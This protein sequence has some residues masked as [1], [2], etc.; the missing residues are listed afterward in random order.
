MQIKEDDFKKIVQYARTILLSE[1]MPVQY[2]GGTSTEM[3]SKTVVQ[4]MPEIITLKGFLEATGEKKERAKPEPAAD[5]KGFAIWWK[6]YPS[7]ANFNYKGM[8]FESPRA[9]RSNYQVCQNLYLRALHENPSVTPEMLLK[10]LQKQV[11]L[12]KKE[13][14]ETGNNKLAYFP[15][16]EVYLR[17]GRYEAFITSQEEEVVEQAQEHNDEN[18]G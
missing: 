5:D 3:V 18:C 9:L 8:K 16:S 14:F 10:A 12:A 2:P 4:A 15:G 7:S 6:A 11:N 1:L 17:Q 13:S